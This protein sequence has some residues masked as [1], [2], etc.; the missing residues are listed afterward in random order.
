VTP[1]Y[2]DSLISLYHGEVREVLRQLPEES[3]H[4]VVTSP[5]YWSLRDYG[6]E[7]QLGL[8][9]TPEEY[10]ANMVDVFREVRRVLRKDGVLWLNI[11][12]S[13][14]GSTNSGGN[15][16]RCGGGTPYRIEGLSAKIPT[17]LKPKDLCLIPARLALA[18]QADGWWVRSDIIWAKPN[19]MPESVTDRPTKAHEYIFMLTKSATYFYDADA[20]RE[21]QLMTRKPGKCHLPGKGV[22]EPGVRDWRG[23]ERYYNPAGRNKRTVW[24]IPTEP[25][26]YAHFATFPGALVDP[27]IKAGT[28][29]RGCCPKC[30]APYKR[31]V[32]DDKQYAA[33]KAR[34]RKRKGA[35][36]RS[37]NLET[38]GLTRG[39]ANKSISAARIT[40]GWQPTCSCDAGE[41]IPC[42]VL[43]PF[44]GSCTTMERAKALGRY[45][46]ALDLK[47]EYLDIGIQYRLKGQEVLAL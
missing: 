33:F 1:Y 14:A 40:T 27:C 16:P 28:S 21:Q 8:E 7:G 46:I 15:T 13:Y 12:D 47:A 17:G 18:L 36:M 32:Q 44:G 34:E 9:A 20:V 10:L 42:T 45:G 38:M 37:S 5:P 26:P 19:P 41:P 29:E 6:V 25:T 24:T 30:L 31:V 23:E 2:T 43:D 39:T 22:D 35:S 11:G 3:V 4:C